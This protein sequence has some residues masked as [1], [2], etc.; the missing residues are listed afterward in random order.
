MTSPMATPC[1]AQIGSPQSRHHTLPGRAD[2][3][4]ST[5]AET[6]KKLGAKAYAVNQEERLVFT[7]MFREQHPYLITIILALYF[8]T[9]KLFYFDATSV[10]NLYC[11]VLV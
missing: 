6:W 9:L 1:S 8:R 3:R 11:S 7:L 4:V 5:K 2:V 10:L